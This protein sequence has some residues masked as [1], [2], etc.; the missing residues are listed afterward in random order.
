MGVGAD[1]EGPRSRPAKPR[2]AVPRKVAGDGRRP[3][4]ARLGRRPR[5]QSWHLSQSQPGDTALELRPWVGAYPHRHAQP[6][7]RDAQASATSNQRRRH[8]PASTATTTLRR[9]EPAR[10]RATPPEET[11]TP[12]P[13]SRLR[14]GSPSHRGAA[15]NFTDSARPFVQD[16]LRADY[17]PIGREP[18]LA[19]G[20]SKA[21]SRRVLRVAT[22]RTAPRSLP[23]AGPFCCVRTSRG[24]APCQVLAATRDA[25]IAFGSPPS[26]S[27]SNHRPPRHA[28]PN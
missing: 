6:S 14:P 18:V 23:L 3:R 2:R 4:P 19:V 1:A 9:A 7:H 22:H 15:N 16:T 12:L 20:E 27:G 24:N 25:S 13:W 5:P 21:R 10:P 28:K 26:I 11:T 17:K 8:P